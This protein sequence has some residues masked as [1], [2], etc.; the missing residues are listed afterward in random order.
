[1]LKYQYLRSEEKAQ[2]ISFRRRKRNVCKL[3]CESFST[4]HPL[5]LLPA[6][7]LPLF[8]L[9]LICSF[10]LLLLFPFH[11]FW[12]HPDQHRSDV[13]ELLV[14]F[15]IFK[16]CVYF[17][18][19]YFLTHKMA[20]SRSIFKATNFIRQMLVTASTQ[21]N[22]WHVGK[23]MPRRL[24][25]QQS[26]GSIYRIHLMIFIHAH[27]G[28][29]LSSTASMVP[30]FQHMPFNMGTTNNN[31]LDETTTF[32]Q[33]PNMHRNICV[34]AWTSMLKILMEFSVFWRCYFNRPIH[35]WWRLPPQYGWSSEL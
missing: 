24:R 17:E 22:L 4:P 35:R 19:A 25:N 32:N 3:K 30:W 10:L 23:A 31:Q 11:Y 14:I 28:P 15:T 9:I 8:L 12:T 26:S 6:G 13:V 34:Y 16:M 5:T 7:W 27:C 29:D 33:I 21:N 2:L 1:M 18:M 20:S